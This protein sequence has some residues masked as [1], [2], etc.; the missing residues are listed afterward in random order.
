MT[1]TALCVS[2]VR[3]APSRSTGKERDT[4]SESDFGGATQERRLC[5][6][7]RASHPE[8]VAPEKLHDRTIISCMSKKLELQEK[9]A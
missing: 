8:A 4:E 7:S 3:F 1:Q 6:T 5:Q 9:D 2:D